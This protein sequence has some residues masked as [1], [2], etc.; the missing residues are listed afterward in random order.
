MKKTLLITI[1]A[2]FFAFVIGI[3]FLTGGDSASASSSS[4]ALDIDGGE[5]SG[6]VSTGGEGTIGIYTSTTGKKYNLYLQ[7]NPAPW[8]GND[9]GNDHSMALAGCRPYCRSYNC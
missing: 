3:C 9:Y 6:E 4:S 5:N 2:S 7:G 8:A 1:I